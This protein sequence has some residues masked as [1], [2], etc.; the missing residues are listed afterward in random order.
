MIITLGAK[1]V[2]ISRNG[3]NRIIKGF[4][5][6][7]VDTTAA[8]D[9]FNGGFVTALLEGQSFEEAIRFA[10]AA[11]A[12]SVTRQGAQSSIPTKQETL[13]FLCET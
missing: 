8:G 9:T 6:Q 5:V 3:E 4:S 13:A 11:A 12:I 2:F 1:G 7:A 10:Q